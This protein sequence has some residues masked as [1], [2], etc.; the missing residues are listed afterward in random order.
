MANNDGGL[1]FAMTLDNDQLKRGADV[2]VNII[3]HMS[4][5]MVSSIGDVGKEMESSAKAQA[6]LI[7]ENLENLKKQ[8]QQLGVVITDASKWGKVPQ[9]LTNAYDK[10][11]IEIKDAEKRISSLGNETAKTEEKHVRFAVQLRHLREEMIAMEMA[12]ERNSDRYREL[13]QRAGE[14]T[15][16]IGDVAQQAQ[17]LAH[18]QSWAQGL[19][20]GISGIT[21]G[22]SAAQ[23]AMALFAGENENLQKIM[24]K[25]QSL[26]AITVGLQQVQAALD[27]DSAFRV[28][29]L[30][31]AKELWG[32]SVQ[33]V[34]TQL[35]INM[36]LS[37]GLVGLIAGGLIVAISAAIVMLNKYKKNQ[38]FISEAQKKHEESMKKYFDSIYESSNNAI[39]SVSLLSLRYKSLGN[40]IQAKTRFIKENKKAFDEL[41]V[42]IRNVT[43]AENL[44]IKN[45][46]QFIQAQI[47]KAK[48]TVI[49]DEADEYIRELVRLEAERDKYIDAHRGDVLEYEDL[50]KSNPF[51]LIDA[52]PAVQAVGQ[53]FTEIGV[54]MGDEQKKIQDKFMRGLDVE[55]QAQNLLEKYGFVLKNEDKVSAKNDPFV[56]MLDARKTFYDKMISY[57]NSGEESLV[58]TGKEMYDSLKSN[59]KTYLEFLKKQQEQILA[60]P[61]E[62]RSAT[63]IK[64]LQTISDRIAEQTRKTVLDEYKTDI[65]REMLNVTNLN[66]QLSL[67]EERRKAIDSENDPLAAVKLEYVVAS[68]EDLRK[69]QQQ[70]AN[71]LLIEH[72]NYLNKRLGQEQE[73][74][75][76]Y[77]ALEAQA[78][79]E[80]NEIRKKQLEDTAKLLKDVYMAGYGS[81]EEFQQ[82]NEENLAN[83]GAFQQ[84]RL[85][86]IEQSEKQ[87]AAATLAGHTQLAAELKAQQNKQLE[88]LGLSMLKEI[89]M[90]EKMFE[91]IGKYSDKGMKSIIANLNKLK[92]W[93]S[94][95]D[96]SKWDQSIFSI[97]DETLKKLS[98]SPELVQAINAAIAKMN[99]EFQTKNVFVRI[100]KGVEDL[101]KAI[102]STSI[103]KFAD[104]DIAIEKLVE[105]S[106]DAMKTLDGVLDM[107]SEVQ[108]AFSGGAEEGGNFFSTISTIFG[109]IASGFQTAGIAGGIAGLFVGALNADAQNGEKNYRAMIERIGKLVDKMNANIAKMTESAFG[110]VGQESINA[111]NDILAQMVENRNELERQYDALPSKDKYGDERRELWSQIEIMDEQIAAFKESIGDSILPNNYLDLANQLTSGIVSAFDNGTDAALAFKKSMADIIKSVVQN[112]IAQFYIGA[113]MQPVFE[114]IEAMAKDAATTGVLNE[115]LLNDVLASAEATMAPMTRELERLKV[116]W[117]KINDFVGD[118][119]NDANSMV[120][121][122]KGITEPTANILVGQINAIRINQ[123]ETSNFI[124]NQLFASIQ[125]IEYN[126]SF[127]LSIDRRLARNSGVINNKNG[128]VV[129]P[130]TA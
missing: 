20:S 125:N 10:I 97:D 21:G 109:S 76:K 85:A 90:F 44:L 16:A 126:T 116:I 122:I 94:K 38:E 17:I 115:N 127:L 108:Q 36:F 58:A 88:E 50:M 55:N 124:R 66:Q 42:S 4:A 59:G 102:K 99:D 91:N 78:S 33:F 63:D 68:E 83:L 98:E 130:W 112:I 71:E 2:S 48:A 72:Q 31:K 56:I 53:Y 69:Q 117:D 51:G 45:T 103:D 123:I 80:T 49:K 96:G 25:V 82:A 67:L 87:I 35:K 52:S 120:A 37:K 28:V 81:I 26:M 121:Q 5:D 104:I 86:I 93:M 15:D 62:N 79:T 12:G 74:Q 30:A 73:F 13:Q 92:E 40:D 23:G 61:K 43:D 9:E 107:V 18:D 118:V 111:Q 84:R 95:N 101:N 47:L 75:I 14:L 70:I 11:T 100:K 114:K 27:K 60:I 39:K 22:F 113:R 89:K 3:K 64:N 105:A 34:N 119:D 6:D 24:L 110:K 29:T 41:G 57:V 32:K 129:L 128:W 77:L 46:G 1:G 106:L 8:Q 7:K 65:E 54:A 19:I